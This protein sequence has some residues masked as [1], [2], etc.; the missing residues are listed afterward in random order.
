MD[1]N[2]ARNNVNN[3]NNEVQSLG[4]L[5]LYCIVVLVVE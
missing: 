3:K 5:I 2:I 1:T 4:L